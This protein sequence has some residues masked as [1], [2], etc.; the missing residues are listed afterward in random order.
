MILGGA[1]KYLELIQEKSSLY[2]ALEELAFSETGYFTDEYERIFI[3]HFGKSSDYERIVTVLSEHHYSLFRPQIASK[4]GIDT[5]GGLTKQLN[6]LESAGFISSATPFHK[7]TNSRLLKYRLS[8][9]YLRFYFSFIK[10]NLKKIKSG[11]QTGIFSRMMQGG[12]FRSWMG[13]AFEYLCMD[14]AAKITEILG[15][16]GIEFTCGPYFESHKKDTPGVQVDFLFDRKDNVITLCEMTYSLTEV[17]I[18][19]I[20]QIERK[21]AALK[22]KFKGKTIQKI[23]ISRSA[24]T[25]ELSA[26]G[27]LYRILRPEMF[28]G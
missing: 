1:P 11:V 16:S 17:G 9:P 5:G 20:P 15:F 6:N 7:G 18:D 28:F 26:S 25:K 3:S 19:I 14:H 22:D 4:A 8:D 10:P 27:Y 23:L 24:P 13:S 12:T 2:M 21:A